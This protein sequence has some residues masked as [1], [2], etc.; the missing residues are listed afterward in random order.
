MLL[1]QNNELLFRFKEKNGLV[2]MQ[3][4]PFHIR[5]LDIENSVTEGLRKPGKCPGVKHFSL[6][7]ASLGK[8]RL[9]YNLTPQ[10]G[11]PFTPYLSR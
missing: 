2:F 3:I 8:F 9:I 11:Y 7:Y 5:Y 4:E 6:Y 10:S 1:L